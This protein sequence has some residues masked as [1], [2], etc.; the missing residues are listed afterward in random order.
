MS[1]NELYE[2]DRKAM[3]LDMAKAATLEKRPE[4]IGQIIG[5]YYFD[6]PYLRELAGLLLNKPRPTRMPFED[7]N[8]YI[9]LL[10]NSAL[11]GYDIKTKEQAFDLVAKNLCI[12]REAVKRA[13]YR[14]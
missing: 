2:G 6:D 12:T 11:K 10:V 14:K 4:L 7:R 9:R 1:R 8:E 5:T 13:Y 3:L